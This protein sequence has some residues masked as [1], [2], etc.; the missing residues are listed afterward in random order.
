MNRR[1]NSRRA[2]WIGALAAVPPPGADSPPFADEPAEDIV[3]ETRRSF[4]EQLQEV[5]AEVVKLAAKSC[6]QIGAATQALLDADL[7]L[8][9]E[10]YDAHREI[11]ERVLQIEHQRVPA[12]RAPTAHGVRPAGDARGAADPARDRAHRPA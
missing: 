3:V 1:V 4:D 10:I 11:K 8:V 9:D 6:E 12:V 5:R 2:R 7:P